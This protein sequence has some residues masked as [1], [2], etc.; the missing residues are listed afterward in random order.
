VAQ[1]PDWLQN[2]SFNDENKSVEIK[3]EHG[4]DHE[5]Y[6]V[7]GLELGDEEGLCIRLVEELRKF[8]KEKRNESGA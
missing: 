8:I 1:N 7:L 2:V 6:R 3:I 4:R 5:L